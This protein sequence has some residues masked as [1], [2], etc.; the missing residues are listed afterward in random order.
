MSLTTQ[1]L[2][3]SES[4]DVSLAVDP[5]G[6]TGSSAVSSHHRREVMCSD[7]CAPADLLR[8]ETLNTVVNT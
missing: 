7:C 6:L 5:G 4:P 2:L 1:I 8:I 3:E